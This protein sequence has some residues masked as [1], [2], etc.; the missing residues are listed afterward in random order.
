MASGARG[1]C[2]GPS[3]KDANLICDSSFFNHGKKHRVDHGKN[4][5]QFY[6]DLFNS[7]KF[8][9]KSVVKS[10]IE[11]LSW[12]NCLLFKPEAGLTPDTRTLTPFKSEPTYWGA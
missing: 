8:R 10:K 9:E 4:K 12:L 11:L 6:Y 5:L 7:V 3:P 2:F 1:C